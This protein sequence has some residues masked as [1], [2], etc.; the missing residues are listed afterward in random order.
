[1]ETLKLESAK[2]IR[3][4]SDIHLDFYVNGKNFK[5]SQLWEP[6]VLPDDKE[7]ILVL[8]GDIWH[9]KK[10]FKFSNYSWFEKISQRFK[11]V[12]VVLGNHDF[13]NGQLPT[14][15]DNFRKYAKEQSL[16]NIIL[17][18]NSQV[19]IG[20]HK[21]VGATLWTN[22]KNRDEQTL[23]QALASS[24]DFKY[25]RYIDPR[26]KG[27]FKRL[28]PKNLLEEHT[29]S[30]N[31][32]FENAKKDYPE[33][34]LWVITHHPPVDVLV[35]D[36]SISEDGDDYGLVTNNYVQ[37]IEN[38]EI[39]FWI[40]G[41]NHQSGSAKVGKTTILANTLGYLSAPQTNEKLNPEFNPWIELEL[42]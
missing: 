8:A 27:T 32:I 30:K 42:N 15:Y 17:L 22:F 16:D 40:H 23:A 20:E 18:Q 19:V 14:E 5:P 7:S 9:A 24:N 34:K 36:P 21:F 1:M 39:D 4:Y 37:E 28:T 6:E 12:L 35:T 41:H 2:K 25:I 13:W 11:Y 10:P 3:F 29:K 33:Q 26:F 31:Y 38:S